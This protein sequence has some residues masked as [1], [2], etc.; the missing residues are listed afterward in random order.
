MGAVAN[1]QTAG[2]L[3]WGRTRRGLVQEIK[4]A[5]DL[6]KQPEMAQKMAKVT[7]V[8]ESSVAA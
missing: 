2:L 8:V 5:V 3:S 6:N 4:S 1:Q 7:A